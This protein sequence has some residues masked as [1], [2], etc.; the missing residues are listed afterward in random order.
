[1]GTKRDALLNDLTLP[2]KAAL[3]AGADMWRTVPIGRL[4]IPAI[5][6][7]D[8]PNGARGADNNMGPR[9]ACFPVGVAMGA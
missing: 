9:S 5:K 4:N 6:V 1:M 8:G 2:E 7:T 3:L